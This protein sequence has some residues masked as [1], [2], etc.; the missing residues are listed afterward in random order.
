MCIRDRANADHVT[1]LDFDNDQWLDVVAAVQ[2]DGEPQLVICAN[3][4]DGT[5]V[6]QAT[7]PCDQP[8]VALTY[9][10]VNR[11]GALDLLTLHANGQLKIW[12][13][14]TGTQAGW[15]RVEL[16]GLNRGGSKNNLYGIGCKVEIKSG[17]I[18]QAR[19]VRRPVTHFGLGARPR[20]DVLRVIW[21]NGVPQNQFQPAANQTIREVQVLKGSCPYLY[22]WDGERFVFVTDLLAAAPL[23]LRPAEGLLAPDNPRELMTVPRH[24]VA[25]R[26]GQ[27]VFQFT[28]E[29]WETVYLDEV[30]L[31]VVDHP[32]HIAVYT[33]QRFRPP[34]YDR[35]APIFTDQRVLPRRAF[36]S[37]GQDVV[38]QLRHFDYRY[39]EKLVPSAYQGI[40]RPHQL[41]LEFGNVGQLDHP[42]LVLG[43]WIFWTDTSINVADSQARQPLAQPP[44][45]EAW[46][47]ERKKWTRADLPFW[48]PNGKNKWVVLDV[49]RAVS[50]DD[51]RLRLR[52]SHQIYWDQAFLA[53]ARPDAAHHVTRLRPEHADLHFGGFHRLYRPVPDGPHLYDYSQSSRQPLWM[54]MSGMA[55]RYGDVTELLRAVDDCMV[56]FTGGDE[57]TIR[58]AA[59]SLPEL[60]PGWVRDYLFYSD[61]WEKD[62]DRN[63]LTGETVTPLPFHGMSSYPY[64]AGESYPDDPFHEAYR[65]HYNTRPIG[66]EAFRRYLKEFR[67]SAAERVPWANEPHVRGDNRK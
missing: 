62:S 22:S 45:L 49:S 46:D 17:A 20:A 19:F 38:E 61:G 14:Q 34:P 23:G 28:S 24:Q 33:D 40:V 12:Q 44:I 7:L 1:V 60:P 52:T 30:S 55:T 37:N 53:N 5:W 9:A 31:W 13:N 26:D 59:E 4:G 39:P 43:C 3:R 15:L 21:S 64:P 41:T 42:L 18:Y 36:D 54:T 27:F 66:P 6:R 58:F 63:T 48:L 16:R 29:L 25:Q 47:P 67:P 35:P 50:R 11:D 10:D 2:V 57:V 65:K 32:P 56:I 51:A 8:L